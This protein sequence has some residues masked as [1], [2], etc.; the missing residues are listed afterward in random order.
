MRPSSPHILLVNPWI[1]D[2]AAYDS[3][4]KPLG[5]L[6]L[7]AILTASGFEIS[8]VDCLNRFHPKAP[9]TDPK[10]RYGRGPYL[11]Q[12]IQKPKGLE[13]VPRRFS[14]YGIHPDW[15]REDLFAVPPP[16]LIL[17]T[18][19]MTYQWPGVRETIGD[20]KK[21]FPKV[22]TVLGGVYA[23]LC[24]DHAVANSG[25]DHIIPGHAEK[26]IFRL[27]TRLTGFLSGSGSASA[28]FD[29]D[30]LDTYPYPALDLQ[31]NISYVP[32]LTSRGCPFSCAYCASS[33]IND[34][35]LRASPDRVVEE[36]VYWHARYHVS[37]FI[38]YDDAFLIDA[39]THAQPILEKVIRSKIKVRFHTPNAL[40]VREI[41]KS[42]AKLLFRAGFE[43]IRLGLETAEADDHRHL[44]Q[45]VTNREFMKAAAHLRDAGFTP[46]QVGAYLLVGL[47][48]QHL[49]SV[50]NSAAFVIRC[51]I[52]P[53]WAYYTPIAGTRLWEQAVRSSRYPLASDPI[54]TNNALFPCSREPFSWERLS[55]LRSLTVRGP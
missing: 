13:D 36:I 27:V 8:Y 32:L 47:P 6:T 31:T 28:G 23:T 46:D 24:H 14:R 9:E 37:D 50:E 10:S 35:F 16:D 38:L 33:L 26:Q 25:A 52:R 40:H 12:R 1:H 19:R 3:W 39:P 4:A 44:D 7:A 55:Y 42:T 18:S 53:V 21:V 51:G 20:L 34:A 15:F 22:P 49:S 11:K 2:F 41:S 30:N 54:F 29:P 17:V 48:G 45:K 5:L 43:T